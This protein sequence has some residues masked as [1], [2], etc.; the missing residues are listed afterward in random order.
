MFFKFSFF[1][2]FLFLGLEKSWEII[3][4]SL[5]CLISLGGQKK[6]NFNIGPFSRGGFEKPNPAR[7]IETLADGS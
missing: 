5:E 4:K 2:I 6:N 7:T 3:K 1:V